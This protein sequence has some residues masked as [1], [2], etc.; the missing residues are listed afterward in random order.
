MY[1][2][3]VQQCNVLTK[4]CSLSFFKILFIHDR[5][6]E[7]MAET[8]A[9]GEAGSMQGNDVGLNPRTPGSH[10]EPKA[11]TQP[12]SHPGGPKLCFHRRKSL[13]QSI[14]VFPQDALHNPW[15]LLG[16]LFCYQ[17]LH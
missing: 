7:G 17:F 3:K 1:K 14:F 10:T 16:D 6:T 13:V 9:E 12:L 4:L 2:N 11:N 5:H 8:W 15:L